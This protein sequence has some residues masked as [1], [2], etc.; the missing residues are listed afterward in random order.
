MFFFI[1][2]RKFLSS[3]CFFVLTSTKSIQFTHK[4]QMFP[5]NKNPDLCFSFLS[6]SISSCALH[7]CLCLFFFFD[8]NMLVCVYMYS[9][10]NTVLGKPVVYSRQK[11]KKTRKYIR[12]YCWNINR[13]RI[14]LF[15]GKDRIR[16]MLKVWFEFKLENSWTRWGK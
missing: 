9:C 5:N 10:I 2:K 12:S 15:M 4:S 7:V 16:V 6:F 14:E 13:K 1:L 3:S 11:G 8:I